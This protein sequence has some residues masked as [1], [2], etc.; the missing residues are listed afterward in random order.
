LKHNRQW[1]AFGVFAVAIVL[2]SLNAFTKAPAVTVG[3]GIAFLGLVVDRLTRI[4]VDVSEVLELQK[5]ERQPVYS[6]ADAMKD[7]QSRLAL[8]RRTQKITIQHLGLNMTDAWKELKDALAKCDAVTVEC[9]V[10]IMTDDP[11]EL[12]PDAAADMIGWCKA[13]PGSMATIAQETPGL[14]TFLRERNT[15]LKLTLKKY[16]GTPRIHGVV[17]TEPFERGYLSFA[18]WVQKAQFEWGGDDYFCFEN[19]TMSA[20]DRRLRQLLRGAFDYHWNRATTATV[21]QYPPP[22]VA[23]PAPVV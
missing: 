5:A 19:G 9:E 22:V 2:Q 16:T 10:L 12:G 3:T 4:R 20:A 6:L 7:V 14:A 18:S 15:S 23:T 1:I 8:V 13:V 11:A 21:F 17:V